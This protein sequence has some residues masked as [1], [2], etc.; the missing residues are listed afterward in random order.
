MA[1]ALLAL[2]VVWLS[3]MLVMFAFSAI[4]GGGVGARGG[5]RGRR[6]AVFVPLFSPVCSGYCA[7]CGARSGG[8]TPGKRARGIRVVVGP[9]RP[10]PPGAALVRVLVRL[11][12]CSFPV[13]FAP[14]L[15]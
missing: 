3:L 12:D 5:V 6:G 15:I 1:A 8:R 7:L 2:V 14:A 4:M 13:P 11:L 9:G 10:V